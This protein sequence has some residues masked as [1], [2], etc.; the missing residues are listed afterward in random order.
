MDANSSRLAV[1]LAT[2]VSFVVFAATF[3]AVSS[4]GRWAIAPVDGVVVGPRFAARYSLRELLLL[5]LQ[6]QL[7]MGLCL[8]LTGEDRGWTI[9][10]MAVSTIA[11]AAIW[12]LSWRR[13]Q[14][15][16]VACPRRRAV[17]LGG[18]APLTC[19]A[20]S[21]GLWSNGRAV[22]EICS[23]GDFVL[24]LWFAGN[25]ASMAAFVAC[26]HTTL[27]VLKSFP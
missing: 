23:T 11:L 17:F 13:L 16:G 5:L 19:V 26:R 8:W 4:L 24:T 1:E 20:I 25:A 18:V 6:M 27:W 22:F 9:L 15:C 12:W 14:A 7:A 10:A 2:S 3:W 21:L